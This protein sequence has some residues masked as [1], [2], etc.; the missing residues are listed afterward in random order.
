MDF[1]GG[2]IAQFIEAYQTAECEHF[3]CLITNYKW[4]FSISL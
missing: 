3:K 2:F 1:G 4:E